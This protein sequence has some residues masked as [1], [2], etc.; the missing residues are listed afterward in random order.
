MIEESL[1]IFNTQHL[2]SLVEHLILA[3]SLNP[4]RVLIICNFVVVISLK[5][6]FLLL[7]FGY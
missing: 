3:N 4:S 7:I 2:A 6:I 5:K 1:W